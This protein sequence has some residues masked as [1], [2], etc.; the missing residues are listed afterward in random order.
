M[1][2]F[3][4]DGS[5][6]IEQRFNGVGTVTITRPA[7][8]TAYTAGDVIGDT[9]GSAIFEI[10][11][12][13]DAGNDYS[14]RIISSATLQ[15]NTGDIVTG[16]SVFNVELYN[17]LPTAI[18]DNSAW[19]LSVNDRTKHLGTIILP[20]P[21]DK[22]ATLKSEADNINKQISLLTGSLFVEL[23]TVGGFI[24]VSACVFILTIHSIK[25]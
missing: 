19:D 11:D 3:S 20:T 1:S 2:K 5:H 22:V 18:A 23:V 15:I 10:V 6:V 4:N 7:N 13:G 8:T 24:P 14:E 16:M 9:N 25:I 12:F 17:A 21:I